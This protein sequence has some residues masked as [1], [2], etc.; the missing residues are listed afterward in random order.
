MVK[1]GCPVDG[2]LMPFTVEDVAFY[3]GANQDFFGG[4][5]GLFTSGPNIMRFM[6]DLALL[7]LCFCQNQRL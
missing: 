7:I 4:F 1:P 6:I 3:L 2:A 5:A